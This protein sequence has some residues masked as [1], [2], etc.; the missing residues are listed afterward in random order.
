MEIEL[1][2]Y[3]FADIDSFKF[4]KPKPGQDFILELEMDIGARNGAGSDRF[5][6]TV[7]NDGGLSAFN[8]RVIAH[9]GFVELAH[10][11]VFKDFD[12]K[13]IIS[14]LQAKVQEIT[15]E[16]W[17]EIVSKLTTFLNYEFDPSTPAWK[18]ITASQKEL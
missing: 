9:Y 14:L 17:D 13:T 4:T 12:E 18:R 1:K 2:Q 15:G 10:V 7:C 11:L 8:K 16:T 3:A 5:S 6:V